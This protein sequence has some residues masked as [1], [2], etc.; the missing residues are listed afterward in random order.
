MPFILL[1]EAIVWEP[2]V[3]MPK[4]LLLVTEESPNITLFFFLWL[5]VDTRICLQVAW[6]M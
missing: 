2:L 1:C 4:K 3:F 6:D 5:I